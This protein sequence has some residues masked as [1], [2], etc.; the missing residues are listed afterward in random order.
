V[1]RE[2]GVERSTVW[3]GTNAIFSF[4]TK[5]EKG[6][7][8]S[9]RVLSIHQLRAPHNPSTQINVFNIHLVYLMITAIVVT[10][11]QVCASAS[12]VCTSSASNCVLDKSAMMV[13]LVLLVLMV[14]MVLMVLL[15]LLKAS[16]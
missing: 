16:S 9:L 4:Q 3:L 13:L 11:F 12:N 2:R 7:Q 8:F 10:F 15:V 5:R 14:L 1:L 6:N